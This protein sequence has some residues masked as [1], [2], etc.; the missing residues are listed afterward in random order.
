M[1]INPIVLS[2]ARALVAA[3][4][5]SNFV[6]KSLAPRSTGG[7]LIAIGLIDPPRRNPGTPNFDKPDPDRPGVIRSAS[8]LT[9]LRDDTPLPPLKLFQR[10]GDARYELLAGFH[11]YHLFAALGYTHV[12]AEVTDWKLDQ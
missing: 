11:R 2:E 1:A 9:A 4:G 12:Y 7:N 5:M 8:I 10:T 3:A 6:I